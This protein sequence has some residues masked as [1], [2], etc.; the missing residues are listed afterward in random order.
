MRVGD[1]GVA[2]TPQA[3]RL[4]GAAGKPHTSAAD[5]RMAELRELEALDVEV[6]RSLD[7]QRPPGPAVPYSRTPDLFVPLLDLL[8][9]QWDATVVLTRRARR[10][11]T[12]TIDGTEDGQAFGCE[13]EGKTMMEAGCRAIAQEYQ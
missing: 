2:A 7:P 6:E 12:C 13:G 8:S 1:L 11:W 10:H 3:Q 4:N 5:Q 9:D